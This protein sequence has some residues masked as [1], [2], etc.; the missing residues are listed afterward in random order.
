MSREKKFVFYNPIDGIQS[1]EK[2]Q[3]FLHRFESDAFNL[4]MLVINP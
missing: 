4:M 2:N 1:D 3:H